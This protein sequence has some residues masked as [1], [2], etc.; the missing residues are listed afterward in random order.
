MPKRSLRTGSKKR[1]TLRLPGGSSG[2]HY[3]RE[4]FGLS[5]CSRCGRILSGTPR[6]APSGIRKIPASQ[7]KVERPYG[8]LLCSSCLQELL[9]QAVRSS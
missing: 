9:K 7:R 2:T 6:L 5:H 3:G 4:K 1:R 8:S